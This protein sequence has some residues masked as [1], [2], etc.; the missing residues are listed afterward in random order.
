MTQQPT[1][2]HKLPAGS[3]KAHIFKTCAT[4]FAKNG[5]AAV[6]VAELCKAVGLGRGAFYY[7]VNSKEDILLGI[8]VSYMETLCADAREALHTPRDPDD[9]ILTLSE[10][11]VRTMFA[12]RAE[13]TVCFREVHLLGAENQR[14][15]TDLHRQYEAIWHEVIRSGI[16]SGHFRALE[17]L[18]VKALLGIYF[19]SFLWLSPSGKS[20][21]AE[22]A[23]R[24]AVLVLDA[25]RSRN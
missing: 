6:G 19:Y 17:K 22:I 3:Q 15:V 12:H 4:L 11:F 24:F 13:M 9:A 20:D 14:L 25:I 23:N 7:H 16:S 2:E 21:A 18:E 8:S 10:L 5:Y 1:L